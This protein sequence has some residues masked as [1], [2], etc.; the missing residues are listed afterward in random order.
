MLQGQG[1]SGGEPHTPELTPSTRMCAG[2]G[3][4]PLALLL[5]LLAPKAA[6]LAFSQLL[7]SRTKP[8]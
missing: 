3:L 8:L 2:V 7:R 1:T 6:E 4:L 5:L